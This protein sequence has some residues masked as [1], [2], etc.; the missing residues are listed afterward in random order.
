MALLTRT[1]VEF[2]DDGLL[3]IVEDRRR[4]VLVGQGIVITTPGSCP[5]ARLVADRR[6]A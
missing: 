4:E 5:I 6:R 3:D 2:I 1:R